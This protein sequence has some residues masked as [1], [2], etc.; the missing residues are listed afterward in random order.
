M[1]QTILRKASFHISTKA[2]KVFFLFILLL[3]AFVLSACYMEPDPIDEIGINL[4]TGAMF[5]PVLTDTPAVTA[6]PTPSPTADVGQV[7]WNEWT[8]GNDDTVTTP[9]PENIITVNNTNML[10][11][12]PVQTT[13]QPQQTPDASVGTLRSGS[14]GAAVTQLQTRLKEL[15]YYTG[16]IDGQYGSGT[17]A[18]V[19]NFQSANNLTADGVA[20]NATQVAVYNF[21][22]IPASSTNA[23]TSP[24]QTS[25]PTAKPTEKPTATP[26]ITGRTNIYLRLG[27]TGSDVKTMQN[28]LISLGY[29]SGTADG[30]FGVTTEE[31]VKAFQKRNSLD[32][33][34]VAGPT[35][36][37]RLYSSS[38]K[39]AASVVANLGP[40]RRGMNNSSVRALQT[41]LKE[42]GYYSGSIDGNFG[43]GTE[44][45]VI[46]FQKAN[47]LTPDGIA[48]TSTQNAIFA[49]GSSS[50]TPSNPSGSSANPSQFAETANINNVRTISSTTNN[51]KTSV[52]A[53]QSVLQSRNFYTGAIDGSYGNGTSAAVSAYQ[54]AVGMRVTGVASPATQRLLYGSYSETGSYPKLDIGSTGNAVRN[55]QYTLYE[56]LYYDGQ[57][58]G[59]YDQSTRNAVLTFQQSNG[60][61][62]DGIAGDITQ[63]KLYSSN[64]IPAGNQ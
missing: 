56:L 17:V 60:L 28:R 14:S 6:T 12:T 52:E 53:L 64:A 8:F 26:G 63:Q 10:N 51:N 33:D 36:L 50:G 59:T 44:A 9:T 19:R 48:G 34:G 20:G 40:L 13:T 42:L 7:N 62:V 29:I 41:K 11:V 5:Q 22:A 27:D 58:T 55:L 57:I 21:Y 1:K 15:G 25:R 46:A 49:S 39:T 23:V 30:V 38:A 18:A 24:A 2:K 3:I 43:V 37:S 4:G 35:T 45:A 32:N 54:Q 31:A 61:F 16:S 47:G